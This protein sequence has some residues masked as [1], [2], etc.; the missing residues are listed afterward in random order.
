MNSALLLLSSLSSSR[1]KDMGLSSPF[2]CRL[3]SK[4]CPRNFFSVLSLERA[5]ENP[6]L[7]ASIAGA[8]ASIT[9]KPSLFNDSTFSPDDTERS[10][11]SSSL[12][13]SFT[14]SI[15][16]HT[17]FLEEILQT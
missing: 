14:P 13:S 2:I 5:T 1:T 17:G 12:I 15:S 7:A 8:N 4:G 10:S 9:D 11:L 6:S 16:P 3:R